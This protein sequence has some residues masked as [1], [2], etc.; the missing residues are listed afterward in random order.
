MKWEYL[1]AIEVIVLIS[2]AVVIQKKFGY[3]C[4]ECFEELVAEGLTTNISKFMN[5][6]KDGYN[7]EAARAAFSVIFSQRSDG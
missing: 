5:S 1:N 3:I 4:E 2:C 7:G 6:S